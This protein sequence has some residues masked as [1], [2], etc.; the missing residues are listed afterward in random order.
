VAYQESEHPRG[1]PGNKG[2]WKEKPDAAVAPLSLVEPDEREPD[3]IELMASNPE[4]K[5]HKRETMVRAAWAFV[6]GGDEQ[7]LVPVFWGASG[8]GKTAMWKKVAKQ[9]G[10]V[11]FHLNAAQIA[12]G[13]LRGLPMI[14]ESETTGA[15]GRPRTISGVEYALQDWILM[16][17]EHAVANP[18]TRVIVFIDEI[19]RAKEGVRQEMLTLL[20]ERQ[21]GTLKLPPNMRFIGAANPPG[22][23][24]DA[25]DLAPQDRARFAHVLDFQGINRADASDRVRRRLGYPAERFDYEDPRSEEQIAED[26]E[27]IDQ[28]IGATCETYPLYGYEDLGMDPSAYEHSGRGLTETDLRMSQLDDMG[29]LATD[30]TWSALCEAVSRFGLAV[31]N[32]KQQPDG[33]YRAVQGEIHRPTV[34][35]LAEM[36]VGEKAGKAFMEHFDKIGLPDTEKLLNE[37]SKHRTLK[38]AD[39]VAA[40]MNSMKFKIAQTAKGISADKPPAGEVREMARWLT[41]MQSFADKQANS[42]ETGGN[43]A[44]LR[45]SIEETM[46]EVNAANPVLLKKIGKALEQDKALEDVRQAAIRLSQSMSDRA[47][48]RSA[49]GAD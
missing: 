36:C 18:A 1:Q 31:P 47:V 14:K 25:I 33:A 21:L 6:S 41:S 7:P 40:A 11:L 48:M 35:K 30:R 32:V 34:L 22:Y 2:Q 24:P 46:R 26:Y 17:Y 39:Q 28:I 44:F 13:E 49:L 27:K 5:F 42:S 19:N 45:T 23:S 37:P 8:T 10:A 38:R 3:V 20:S 9:N 12:D 4:L 29:G 43:A 16:P 15:D